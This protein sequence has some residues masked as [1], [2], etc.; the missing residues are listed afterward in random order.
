MSA[1]MLRVPRSVSPRMS[2][3]G[4]SQAAKDM[5]K[6]LSFAS[7]QYWN[8]EAHHLPASSAPAVMVRSVSWNSGV[9]QKKLRF[10]QPDHMKRR[11][12]MV[13]AKPAIEVNWRG[14]HLPSMK[15]DGS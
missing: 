2:N 5:G 7:P 6:P 13:C 3:G 14:A 9:D 11:H 8:C 12:G 15:P 1:R 4:Q 10:I